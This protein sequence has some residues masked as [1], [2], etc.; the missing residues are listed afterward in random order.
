MTATKNYIQVS[1]T[2]YLAESGCQVYGLRTLNERQETHRLCVYVVHTHSARLYYIIASCGVYSVK[3]RNVNLTV[4]IDGIVKT[5]CRTHNIGEGRK[6]VM[7]LP[8]KAGATESQY[9]LK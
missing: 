4:I 7:P 1:G 6:N 5:F 8:L 3:I 2:H 9:H